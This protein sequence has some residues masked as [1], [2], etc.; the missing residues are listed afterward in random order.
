MA[1]DRVETIMLNR[2]TFAKV[3]GATAPGGC[4]W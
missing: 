1:V 2:R 4:T 3:L